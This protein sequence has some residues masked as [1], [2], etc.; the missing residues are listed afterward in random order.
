VECNGVVLVEDVVNSVKVCWMAV[1]EGDEP[2][3]MFGSWHDIRQIGLR[4][5]H[6][7]SVISGVH[8]AAMLDFDHARDLIFYSERNAL[9]VYS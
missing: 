7:R 8:R 6:Y 9:F 4:S 5:G 3:L 2:Q 1:L